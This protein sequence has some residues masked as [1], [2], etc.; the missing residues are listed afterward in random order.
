MGRLAQAAATL[1]S[2]SHVDL[3][4]FMPAALNDSHRHAAN[5]L[6]GDLHQLL[7]VVQGACV[8]AHSHEQLSCT[9]PRVQLGRFEW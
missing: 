2:K 9:T 4:A 8:V 1:A 7:A 3:P 5:A 6:K